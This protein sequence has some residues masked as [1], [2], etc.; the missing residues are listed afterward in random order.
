MACEAQ[1][2]A[3]TA[4]ITICMRC[5]TTIGIAMSPC[6]PK[7]SG[8]DSSTVMATGSVFWLDVMMVALRSLRPRGSSPHPTPPLTVMGI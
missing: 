5:A 3:S 6:S 4:S 1:R 2:A 8:K 7:L